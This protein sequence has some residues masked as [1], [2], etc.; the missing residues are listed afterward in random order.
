MN[1]TL[2]IFV[3]GALTLSGCASTKNEKTNEMAPYEKAQLESKKET[4]EILGKAALLSS[5]AQAVLAKTEQAY[6]QPLLDADQIRQARAQNET[7][8]RG[9]EKTIPIS[10]AAAPEPVLT[11]L[12]NASGY[13]LDY[14]NQR[15]PIPEDV[16][17]TGEP[18]NIKQLIDI[19]DQQTD[20]YIKD[21]II[22]D[23]F[24]KKLIT[25]F[26]EKF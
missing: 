11:M 15:P 22:T 6:Y 10:W 3:A 7:I 1:K 23:T 26:Y 2:F 17:I 12:A 4:M 16:Y 20:G 21:I 24:D 18:K 19:I 13:I 8:P 9:M 14:A 5:K 25:V